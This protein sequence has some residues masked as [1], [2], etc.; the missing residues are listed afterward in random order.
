MM[1]IFAGARPAMACEICQIVGHDIHHHHHHETKIKKEVLVTDGKY[2]VVTGVCLPA[3]A[4]LM[5]MRM[6]PAMSSTRQIN[7][8]R[9]D[10]S[11]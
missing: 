5:T 9:F 10:S 2:E 1:A 4:A 11:A 6:K 8:E 3:F 7:C